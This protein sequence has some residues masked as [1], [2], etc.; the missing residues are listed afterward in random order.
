M[1]IINEYQ[2][3]NGATAIV[4]PVTVAEQNEAE[5]IFHQKM[6]YA[7]VSNVDVHS[8]TLETEEGFQV[9]RGCYKH[10]IDS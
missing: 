4:T 1:Y 9:M 3:T 2:T 7:A 10:N 6:S 5:S 8:V